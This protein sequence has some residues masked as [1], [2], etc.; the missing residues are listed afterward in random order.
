MKGFWLAWL[1]GLV[2][3][4]QQAD[5]VILIETSRYT[6]GA[7]LQA[8]L[9]ALTGLCGRSDA[10]VKVGTFSH[11]R[12]GRPVTWITTPTMPLSERGVC[13]QVFRNAWRQCLDTVPAI[14]LYSAIEQALG[15]GG[16][17][18]VILLVSGYEGGS[19]SGLGDIQK[20]AQ[21]KGVSLYAAAIGWPTEGAQKR[22]KDLV[23]YYDRGSEGFFLA[24]GNAPDALSL[25]DFVL[26]ALGKGKSASRSAQAPPAAGDSPKPAPETSEKGT[27][28]QWA[29]IALVAVGAGLLV[30][31]AV[32]LLSGR[33]SSSAP[34]AAP[35]TASAASSSSTAP[36]EVTPVR[37]PV[38]TLR[39]LVIYYPHGQQTVNLSPSTAPITI[40]RAPDNTLVI[41]DPTVSSRHARLYL[42]GTQ[43]YVQDLGSTNGTFV[44]E[45]RVTQHPVQIGDKIRLGAIVIQLAG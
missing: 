5:A 36:T 40:G 26:A 45:A 44:N 30:F 34:V 24:A 18:I 32:T 25:Q 43:W 39:R 20:L 19:A 16:A 3:Y 17:P 35:P 14:A 42:Q 28:P 4:A 21:Q 2:L 41:G 22:L 38:P 11:S 1:G 6:C 23:G 31:L 15:Q 7:P 37:P 29:W 9:N 8:A 10:V 12:G 27:L 33:K 13:G